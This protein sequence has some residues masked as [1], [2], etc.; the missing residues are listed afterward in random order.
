M[1]LLLTFLDFPETVVLLPQINYFPQNL[2]T[3]ITLQ[4]RRLFKKVEITVATKLR[5][6]FLKLFKIENSL[7]LSTACFVVYRAW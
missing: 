5:L 1:Q 3:T 2:V 6:V 7:L 4:V